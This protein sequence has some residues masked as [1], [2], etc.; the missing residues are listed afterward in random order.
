MIGTIKNGE[1]S[2]LPGI[3]CD[4]ERVNYEYL[5]S[6]E[7]KK[8]LQNYYY[9]AGINVPGIQWFENIHQGWESPNCQLR[10][11]FLGHW[12][13][14]AAITVANKQ[15]AVLKAKINFI[16]EEIERC[17]KA[18][19]GKWA[20]SIP[21]KYFAK[22]EKNEY[23]W[24]PQYTVHKLIMGLTDAYK[25]A[26]NRKA[27]TILSNLADWFLKWTEKV[28]KSDNPEAINCG[29]NGGMLE[30]W[31]ELFALTGKPKYQTLYEPVSYTH[32]TLPT[33]A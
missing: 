16:I 9:E 27:L 23:I 11:H 18:N 5:L 14:A 25:Y 2:L 4:R 28:L 33:K 32:L 7:P 19:G 13:S 1:V 22:L 31:A 24:S 21:E 3:F 26:G 30:A 17:Q 20:C 29:E 12:L 8:L 15:D 6:L 10:G